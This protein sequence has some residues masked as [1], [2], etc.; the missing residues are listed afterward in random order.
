MRIDHGPVQANTMSYPQRQPQSHRPTH[1]QS[2]HAAAEIYKPARSPLSAP[3][4]LQ[5]ANSPAVATAN[6][7]QVQVSQRY[8]PTQPPPPTQQTSQQQA[9]AGTVTSP[10]I[11]GVYRDYRQNRI[12]LLHPMSEYGPGRARE[13]PPMHTTIIQPVCIDGSATSPSMGGGQQPLKKIRLQDNKETLQPLR[14]DTREQPIYNPQVEAISPTLPDHL[15]QEDQAFRTTK[16]ELIQQIGKVDREIAKAEAQ[17]AILKKKQQELEEIAN[18]PSVKSEVEE[19]T[20]PKH[21]SLPQ[22]IYAENRKKAQ[23][24]H[25]KLDALGPK[26]DFPLYNQPSDTTVYHENKRKHM[27]FKRRLLEYFKKRN[28]EK[29]ARNTYLTETYSKLM[30]EWL[31]KVDKIESSTKRKAKEAKNRE[32]F[33]KVFPEL[34]KH[35]EDKERFNRVGSRV[36]SEADM[37]EIMDNLQEQALEDKKM[38]SYAVI[39]P[40]LLDAKER[41]IQYQDNNGHIEDMEAVYKSRQ[42]LNIWTPSEKEIFREKYLQ[43]PKNFC[44]IAAC[45][46]RKSVSDCVQ[47]YYLSKKTENYKQLLRKSRQRSRSS[48]NN[49]QKVNSSANTSVVDILTTG[50]TTRLQREQQQKT[51][52]QQNRETQPDSASN[53]RNTP[54]PA[55]SSTSSIPS[56]VASVPTSV[57]P[58][59]SNTP[60]PPSTIAASTGTTSPTST[61]TSTASAASN[62]ANNVA[63]GTSLTGGGCSGTAGPSSSATVLTSTASSNSNLTV[64]S[65]SSNI[66][67]SSLSS[68]SGNNSTSVT[69]ASVTNN[70]TTSNSASTLSGDAAKTSNNDKSDNNEFFEENKEG[71]LTATAAGDSS[72]NL[73]A[74]DCSNSN[75]NGIN[76]GNNASGGATSIDVNSTISSTSSTSAIGASVTTA[77]AMLMDEVSI[78]KETD[79]PQ[80]NTSDQ[81]TC[82]S[83]SKKKKERR[84]D[85]EN[86]AMETSDE[87]T[88]SLQDKSVQGRCI[89]CETQLGPQLPSRPLPP[90]QASMY[91]LREGDVPPNSRV[92][93]T[94]RCKY[95]RSRYTHCPLPTCPNSR[96]RVKRLRSFPYHLLDLPPDVREPLLAEFRIPSG[97][98]KC[99]SACFNRIQ[100][101]LG[102]VEEWPE[103]EINQLKAALTELGANWQLIGERLNK[104]P[105]MVRSFY[106]ANRKRLNLENC[107]GDRKPTLT[108]EEESG[109]STSSCEE[110]LR[111]RERHSSDTASAVSE[112]PPVQNAQNTIKKEDYDSS[113]TE[114]A[115]EAQ[116]PDHYQTSATI[117][118]VVDGQARP[119]SSPFSVKDLVLN[120]IEYSLKKNHTGAAQQSTQPPPTSGGGMAPTISSILNNDSNEVTI[121]GEYSLNNQ[122]NQINQ[123]NQ[124]RNDLSIAKLTPLIAATIT[125]VTGPITAQPQPPTHESLASSRDD[126]VVLHVHDGR[127]SIV[128]ST[129]SEETLDLSIKKPREL[130]PPPIHKM[131]RENYM[132]HQDRKSPAYMR[133]SSQSK[134][135]SPKPANPK[136]GSITMGTPIINQP[137]RYEGLLRQMPEAK[138]GSITQGTPIHIP[139]HLQQQPD[140]RMYEYFKNT[141]QPQQFS[142]QSQQ[143]SP[144]YKMQQALYTVE[145][146]QQQQRQIIIND[147]ITSKQM[148]GGRRNDKS[149]YHA[150]S[151]SHRTP[152]PTTHSQ[153]QQQ[154]QHQQSQTP[155]PQQ[156]Q[157]VIQRHSRPYLPPGH[158]KLSS[159]VD[160]AVQQ[161]SLPVP[162]APHE[163]LGKTMAD[164]LLEHSRY[165]MLQQQQQQQQ[166]RQ[167]QQRMDDHRRSSN[168]HQPSQPTRSQ[169][170]TSQQQPP[171]QQRTDN[172]LTAASLI[173]AI[174]THQINQTAEGNREVVANARD[175]PRPSDLLFQSFHRDPPVQPSNQQLDNNGDRPPSVISVDLDSV[176][177]G[178]AGVSGISDVVSNKNLTVK[179]LTDSV[180]S[181]D[182][183]TSRQSFYHSQ[184]SINEQWKRRMQKPEEKRANTPQNPQPQ[185]PDE[186][187]IIRIAQPPQ[188]KYHVEPVSPPDNNHWPSTAE[189]NYRRYAQPQSHMS[190]LDYVKNRIVEVMRTEDDKKEIHE[191]PHSQ[192][193]NNRNADSPGEMVIDEE[194]EGDY[195]QQREGIATQQTQQQSQQASQQ[196]QSAGGTSV[197]APPVSN[198][199]YSFVHKDST[200]S[201]ANDANRSEPKPLLSAQYEPLSDEEM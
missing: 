143:Q 37:E 182:F 192:Q 72:S 31:R 140:K 119:S 129:A 2:S 57:L 163:G 6:I 193:E 86:A 173:D 5:Q 108:D 13:P 190:P 186:R 78:K 115:D 18:K 39:P 54:P 131:H 43:H 123:L 148:L 62:I 42:F 135:P 44:A 120:V 59:S 114:T 10:I 150:S 53:T 84:K 155:Q 90:S 89:V 46:D 70:S 95:V 138:M 174:I 38:R 125:P 30:Q 141:P 136:A 185:Q 83:E 181:H 8:A 198:Y 19:D 102:P 152:P 45:L 157:G 22:K 17:I 73:K 56:A 104:Q 166:M 100:R 15:Q 99:C 11:S 117:T 96:G 41:K 4:Y 26:I 93:N 24:A 170:P 92:C 97:V 128:Q 169:L 82:V 7:S 124:R 110:P 130:P 1:N 52:V 112:S 65:N 32:F 74:S 118:P 116:T 80:E 178:V 175:P 134:M 23:N 35:R 58:P 36:K 153:S 177:G 111:D 103:E 122:I 194:K 50:V 33:E 162:N 27:A 200:S 76:A 61:M 66:G 171:Q 187:Q 154:P 168:Y 127:T 20:Q 161:P 195:P 139:Q 126:L 29:E 14:I 81:N 75:N 165:Q 21:Q 188:Q 98:T 164:N 156:R 25:A 85:K 109:S 151:P 88:S 144:Q 180:I 60:S 145:Q 158:E 87:E 64:I 55:T 101:R 199:Q 16:D 183:S 49:T 189:Q 176:G 142:S 132:Y 91:G 3:R 47:Y 133:T 9:A 94:C 51:M 201:T 121:V 12:S 196:N 191:N 179:E 63:S 146:Q 159:L 160:I 71:V 113:A 197:S 28:S 68:S 77:A 79:S 184:D 69:T 167:Q 149:Y 48:R 40:I 147:Y 34:R 106:A 107:L 172:T 67:S 105:H 137:S